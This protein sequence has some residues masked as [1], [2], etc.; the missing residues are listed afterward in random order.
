MLKLTHPNIIQI[1]EYND[2]AYIAN[3]RGESSPVYSLA[4]EL[5]GGGELFDF[6]ALTGHFSEDIAR[7]YFHQLCDALEYM[8]GNGI[9][10][11]DLK[12][13]NIILND[14]FKLKLADFG[15]ASA[16]SKNES[17]K[18]SSNYMAPEI[19]KGKKYSGKHVD[20]FSAGAILFIMATGMA[21]FKK[22][23][24]KDR[25]YTFI[26]KNKP[27]EFWNKH[28]VNLNSSGRDCLSTNLQKLIESMI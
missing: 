2:E 5:A 4:L 10:H 9:S 25:Y 3:S 1:L 27:T 13:E 24:S 18:G 26:R 28:E 20:I 14:D 21:P 16:K 19:L 12:P 22:A 23:S 7:F 8:H 6:I 15:L 11:R 17:F